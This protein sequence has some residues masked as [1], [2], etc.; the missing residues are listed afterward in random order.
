MLARSAGICR[1][2][3]GRR[4]TAATA[5][6]D[7]MAVRVRH[8]SSSVVC[9]CWE[10]AGAYTL[11]GF[12]IVDALLTQPPTNGERERKERD[13]WS[14]SLRPPRVDESLRDAQKGAISYAR[15]ELLSALPSFLPSAENRASSSLVVTAWRA[16][17]LL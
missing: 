6:N 1:N 13:S 9:G 4:M 17:P 8:R 5:S 11:S 2:Q 16:H 10:G 15:P 14:P 3:N 7:T 12:P